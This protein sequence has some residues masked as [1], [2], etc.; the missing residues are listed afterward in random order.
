[1]LYFFAISSALFLTYNI[2][3]TVGF[4]FIVFSF[5]GIYGLKTGVQPVLQSNSIPFKVSFIGSNPSI[6]HE[7]TLL[8]PNIFTAFSKIE[9]NY[10]NQYH[11]C[12]KH[13]VFLFHH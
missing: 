3:S 1:M 10:P 13:N 6:I 11:I 4:L 7:R 2:S 5:I 9:Y 12:Y 8:V